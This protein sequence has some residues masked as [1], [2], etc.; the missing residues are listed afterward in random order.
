MTGLSL[1]W[2]KF[3]EIVKILGSSWTSHSSNIYLIYFKFK[4]SGDIEGKSKKGTEK[5]NS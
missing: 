3:V 5:E 4:N 1:A 2:T